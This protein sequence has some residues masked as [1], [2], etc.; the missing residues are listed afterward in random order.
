[1]IKYFTAGET[2]YGAKILQKLTFFLVSNYKSFSEL[3]EPLKKQTN[4]TEQEKKFQM[5]YN[6][7]VAPAIFI[8]ILRFCWFCNIVV[9]NIAKF[10]QNVDCRWDKFVKINYCP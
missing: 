9:L 5:L 4:G 10:G 7:Y 8:L 2:D 6:I 3:G 1:M